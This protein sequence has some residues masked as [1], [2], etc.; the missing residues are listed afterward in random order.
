MM[1]KILCITLTFAFMKTIVIIPVLANKEH[2]AFLSERDRI[3]NSNKSYHEKQNELR[4]KSE[5]EQ[6]RIQNELSGTAK[7]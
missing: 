4:T 2:D 5:T 7:A 1:R 3:I 6:R